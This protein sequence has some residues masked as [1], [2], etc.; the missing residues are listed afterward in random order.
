MSISGTSHMRIV[1]GLKQIALRGSWK[2]KGSRVSQITDRPPTPSSGPPSEN[3]VG[4]MPST[5]CKL[6]DLYFV[7]LVFRLGPR[8]EILASPVEMA[9]CVGDLPLCQLDKTSLE[10]ST[11]TMYR[12]RSPSLSFW[13]RFRSCK[14]PA[15]ASFTSF[16][17]TPN[18]CSSYSA[19]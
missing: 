6:P 12:R 3:I 17:D 7:H 19:S 5:E 18:A 13:N 1:R 2:I 10:G 15:L 11:H 8:L 14:T 16:S 9:P 4:Q